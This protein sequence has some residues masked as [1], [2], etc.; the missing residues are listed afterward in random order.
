VCVDGSGYSKSVPRSS[1]LQLTRVLILQ[2]VLAEYRRAVFDALAEHYSVTVAHCGPVMR[3]PKNQF[4]ERRL[5]LRSLGRFRFPSLRDLRPLVADSDAVIAM[6]DL[7]W[8]GYCLSGL[9]H[10]AGKRWILWGHRYGHSSVANSIRNTIMRSADALLLYG[11][12][13]VD[14]MV[15]AGVERRRIFV[16]PNTVAVSNHQDLGGADKDAFIFVGRLQERKR[17]PDAIEAFARVI[18][19]NGCGLKFHIVGEGAIETD[20]RRMAERLGVSGAVE[21]H[22]AITDD[23]RLSEL[24]RRS[25]AYVSP[26]P[27]GLSVL[28]SFAYG[29]PV[30]TLRSGYHGPEFHNIR[31]GANGFI[32]DDALGLAKYM[33]ILIEDRSVAA[34]MGSAAYSLYASGRTIGAMVDG[35][36]SAIEGRDFGSHRRV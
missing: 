28:H 11:W 29:V 16:A 36:R 21:F 25:V 10:G 7:F 22:G 20:L 18:A 27:V 17:L 32:A 31:H 23:E 5:P 19:D 12:E 15:A 1:G 13:H 9:S 14:E 24:F 2:G 6:F 34:R 30:L 35:I 4:V 3:S 33:R 8:P 26:G